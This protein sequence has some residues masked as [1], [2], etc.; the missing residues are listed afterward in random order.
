MGKVYVRMTDKGSIIQLTEQGKVVKGDKIVEVE[1]TAQVKKAC[2]SGVLTKVTQSEYD[3]ANTAATKAVDKAEG[4]PT[5]EEQLAAEAAAQKAQADE[6]KQKALADEEAKKQTEEAN[7]RL[8]AQKAAEK[9]KD[10]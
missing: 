7:K 4:G 5:K 3:K 10:K 2:Q 8:A 9:E 6:A 1:E